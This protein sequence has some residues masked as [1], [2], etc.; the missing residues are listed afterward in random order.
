MTVTLEDDQVKEVRALVAAG[1]SASISAFVKHA[2][3]VALFDVA[4]WARC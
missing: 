4:E 3:A 2:V 1:E